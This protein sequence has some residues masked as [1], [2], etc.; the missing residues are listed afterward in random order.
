MASAATS[1]WTFKD[2][3]GVLRT[4]GRRVFRQEFQVFA[5]PLART[6]GQLAPDAPQHR[7]GGLAACL[8]VSEVLPRPSARE[9]ASRES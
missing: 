4:L 3:E 8:V 7:A 6:A 9:F 1:R 5:V 2:R